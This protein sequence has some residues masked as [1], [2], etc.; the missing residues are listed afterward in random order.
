MKRCIVLSGIILN[1]CV[2]LNNVYG[3]H[4]HDL[5][6]ASAKQKNKKVTYI[7]SGDSTRENSFNFMIAYYK[8]QFEKINVKVINNAS[9]GLDAKDWKANVRKHACLENAIANTGGRGENTIMEYSLGINDQGRSTSRQEQKKRYKDGIQAYIKAKPKATVILSVPVAHSGNQSRNEELY[10]IYQELA[11]E[12]N[13]M[14]IDT[15]AATKDVHGDR[16]YYADGTHP[17]QWGSR[18]IVNYI[19]NQLL[20]ASLYDKVTLEEAPRKQAENDKE[21]SSGFEKGYYSDSTSHWGEPVNSTIG[22]RLKEITVEP[23]FVLKIKTD[24]SINQAFF[25]D[26]EGNYIYKRSLRKSCN[27]DYADI[28]IPPAGTKLRLTL[29]LEDPSYTPDS[30]KISVKYNINKVNYMSIDDINKGLKIGLRKVRRK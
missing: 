5:F 9:S 27:K 4:V 16:K 11:Q 28:V 12:L 17:G 22:W 23:N 20:P 1:L 15:L 2:L 18:R 3:N 10:D 25:M 26:T 19:I 21:L 8:S 14:L 6:I 13:L 7:I 24:A 29:S 30:S